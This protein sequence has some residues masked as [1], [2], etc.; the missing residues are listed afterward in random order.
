MA[1]VTKPVAKALPKKTGSAP[2]KKPVGNKQE[3]LVK[4]EAPGVV[5]VEGIVNSMTG[6]VKEG[7]TIMLSHKRRGSSRQIVAPIPFKRIRFARGVLRKGQRVQI[8]Y[9]SDNHVFSM[10]RRCELT[11]DIDSETGLMK[12][13]DEKGLPFLIHEENINAV[14]TTPVETPP[15]KVS[16]KG[17]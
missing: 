9:I 13:V 17:G 12:G 10:L 16:A 2:A 1:V 3:F 8:G 14:T 7:G 5:I 4:F 11:G 15:I 6:N